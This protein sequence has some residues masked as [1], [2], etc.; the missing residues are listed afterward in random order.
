MVLCEVLAVCWH[1]IWNPVLSLCCHYQ[2]GLRIEDI[3]YRRTPGKSGLIMPLCAG[4]YSVMKVFGRLP[5]APWIT[6]GHHVKHHCCSPSDHLC[7]SPRTSHQRLLGRAPLRD[8]QAVAPCAPGEK[9]C[10]SVL[11]FV[12]VCPH[13]HGALTGQ[14]QSGAS[15]MFSFRSDGRRRVVLGGGAI[16]ARRHP[17]V[18]PT[19]RRF[20]SEAKNGRHSC[21]RVSFF[22]IHV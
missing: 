13:L 9:A 20:S 2:V 17:L 21:A 1:I 19:Q 18:D 16:T 12:F 22:C 10:V 14:V 6:I 11:R 7:H 8:G 5:H 15:C 3:F 4:S